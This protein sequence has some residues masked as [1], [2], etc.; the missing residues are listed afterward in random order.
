MM[1]LFLLSAEGRG[2]VGGGDGGRGSR[3]VN[4]ES[5]GREGEEGEGWW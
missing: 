4:V 1:L 2:C 5:R 3:R